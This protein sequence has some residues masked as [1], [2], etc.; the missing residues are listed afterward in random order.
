M[1]E[2]F[3]LPVSHTTTNG[4]LYELSEEIG[5]MFV[6]KY[7]ELFSIARCHSLDDVLRHQIR[8]FIHLADSQ[9][10]IASKREQMLLQTA[11]LTWIEQLPSLYQDRILELFSR[12]VTQKAW[13]RSYRDRE[14]SAF[15]SNFLQ[16]HTIYYHLYFVQ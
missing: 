4:E 14:L 15:L 16:V 12:E 6:A 9:Y 1:A 2:Y 11:L 7:N 3:R 10:L 13:K 5:N 8:L